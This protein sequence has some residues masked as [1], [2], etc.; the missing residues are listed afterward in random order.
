MPLKSR[1]TKRTTLP[2][3]PLLP[4]LFSPLHLR[5]PFSLYFF[6]CSFLPGHIHPF[7][8][9]IFVLTAAK[10]TSLF[11]SLNHGR[12]ILFLLSLVV[13]LLQPLLL[14]PLLFPLVVLLKQPLVTISNTTTTLDFFLFPFL[15]W[16]HGTYF[17]III[18]LLLLLLLLLL[19]L[20]LLLQLLLL[21]III[22]NPNP[23]TPTTAAVANE[24]QRLPGAG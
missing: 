2:Q 3:L 22:S 5:L 20:A 14:L 11:R 6:S 17:S 10:T 1:A 24:R 23:P 15:S 21:L 4:L 12:S 19:Q 18:L 16:G 7:L 8:H 9:L 13:P